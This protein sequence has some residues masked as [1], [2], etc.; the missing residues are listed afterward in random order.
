LDWKEQK[1]KTKKLMM[2]VLNNL[3]GKC[4]TL[5]QKI[6]VINTGIMSR[7]RYQMEVVDFSVK[8]LN[9]INWVLSRFLEREGRL[10]VPGSH[11]HWCQEKK[12]FGR[13]LENIEEVFKSTK[14]AA[15]IDRGRNG[16][17]STLKAVLRERI[18]VSDMIVD[19]KKEWN[20]KES[21]VRD[22][23]YWRE[24]GGR[25]IL[26][27]N[28]RKKLKNKNKKLKIK[29]ETKKEEMRNQ[30]NGSGLKGKEKDEIEM[31]L[32]GKKE[33]KPE[34]MQAVNKK[35]LRGITEGA[36]FSR[37]FNCHV[38]FT[39]ASERKEENKKQKASAVFFGENNNFNI[40]FQREGTSNNNEGEV[41]AVCHALRMWPFNKPLLIATDSQ[42]VTE[43]MDKIEKGE[44]RWEEESVAV[45]RLNETMRERKKRNC[46]TE[47]T[48]IYSHLVDEK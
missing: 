15:E 3:R 9:Q 44:L 43:K 40:S 6:K 20:M 16:G 28:E 5:E 39:D 33:L 12:S 23:E 22:E 27:Q 31:R 19:E 4:P 47:W 8:E 35:R 48:H 46:K 29:K 17:D 2:T 37:E 30:L 24:L 32:F 26:I 7:Y 13:G 45:R 25:E 41:E 42:F 38:V 10:R 1:G 21:E 34:W 18:L 11:S 36:F 14:L